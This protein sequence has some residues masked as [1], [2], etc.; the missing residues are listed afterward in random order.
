L[1][2]GVAGKA[3]FINA[4]ATILNLPLWP[5]SPN[6]AKDYD[7]RREYAE[8]GLLSMQK[9][10]R[11]NVKSRSIT[12]TVVRSPIGKKWGVLVLDSRHPDGVSDN[13]EKQAL[14][15]LSAAIMSTIV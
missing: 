14:V 2:E 15:E 3:W 4:S 11:L 13:A 9:A 10:V 5:E 12:A 7:I 6:G 1:N 8:R